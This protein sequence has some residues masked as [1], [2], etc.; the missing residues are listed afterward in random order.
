MFRHKHYVPILKGKAGEYQAL[1]VL[2]PT[3]K[4]GMTPLIEIPSIPWNFEADQSS[5]TI[6]RHLKNVAENVD[7]C[8][9]KAP[10]FVDLVWIDAAERMADGR[11][12]VTYV[13]DEMRALGIQSI[14]VTGLGRD[15]S[16]QTAVRAVAAIDERG[17]C[18]RIE[19][20]DFEDE[21]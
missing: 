4:S 6:D 12:P 17:A 15:G 20:T 8:W 19:G 21:V 2:P 3:E 10:I 11:H 16:Y 1:N 7:S 9:G 14:P 5:T 18:I 13:L